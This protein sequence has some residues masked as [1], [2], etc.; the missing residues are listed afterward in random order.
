[1]IGSKAASSRSQCS[2]PGHILDVHRRDVP[3]FEIVCGACNLGA[4]R[5][6]DNMPLIYVD[7][8]GG[9]TCFNVLLYGVHVW[10]V[11]YTVRP[12]HLS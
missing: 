5:K 6:R 8:T 3:F 7:A 9:T 10:H 4:L 12:D 1:M 11:S 2:S